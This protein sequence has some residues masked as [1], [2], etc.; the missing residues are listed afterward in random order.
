MQEAA[1]PAPETK[2][3]RSSEA[4]APDASARLVLPEPDEDFLVARLQAIG[5][6]RAA[7]STIEVGKDVSSL[8]KGLSPETLQEQQARARRELAAA[9][10]AAPASREGTRRKQ[11]APQRLADMT[12]AAA[13]TAAEAASTSRKRARS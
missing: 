4:L 8:R 13:A 1:A 7:Q 3:A 6:S 10:V 5:L 12:A 2:K 11:A 9:R